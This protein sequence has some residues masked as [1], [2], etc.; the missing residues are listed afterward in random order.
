M[1]FNFINESEFYYSGIMYA[2]IYYTGLFGQIIFDPLDV[3]GWQRDEQWINTATLTGRWEFFDLYIEYLLTNGHADSLRIFAK[4]LSN[5][6]IDPLFITTVIINH[7]VSKELYTPQDYETATDIFK[8]EIPQNY[9]DDGLWNLDWDEAP[10]QVSLL[11]K[12]LA[13]IPEFQLK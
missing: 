11:L 8:W 7:F 1:I 5:D 13:T 3:S 12:H 9:Y 4:N 2:F 6:S 10:F